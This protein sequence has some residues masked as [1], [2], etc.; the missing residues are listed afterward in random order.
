M[1]NCQLCGYAGCLM[2]YYNPGQGTPASWHTDCLQRQF[3]ALRK[4]IEAMQPATVQ[5][6]SKPATVDAPADAADLAV[7]R[8]WLAN[9]PWPPPGKT[10]AERLGNLSAEWTAALATPRMDAQLAELEQWRKAL[11]WLK[12]SM[13]GTWLL[14]IVR[15]GTT[16]SYVMPT[17]GEWL[18][19]RGGPRYPSRDAAMRA[20]E[21]PF[22]LPKCRVEGEP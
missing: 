3:V 4:Q 19:G 8:A 13:D 2:P 15:T 21:S 11:V 16:L 10:L 9:L 6:T 7:F 22:G 14:C 12:D 20:A 17:D 5:P 1:N 18:V